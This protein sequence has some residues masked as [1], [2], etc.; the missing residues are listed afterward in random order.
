MPNDTIVAIAT[1][2][3]V[4]ALSIIRMSGPASI[5][6]AAGLARVEPPDLP[7]YGRMAARLHLPPPWPPVPAECWVMRAPHSFTREDVIELHLPGSLPLAEA[8][9]AACLDAGA[10]LAEPGEFTRRALR[11]G[12]IDL[13]RA[14][15]IAALVAAEDEAS[16]RAARARL[17]GEFSRRVRELRERCVH[18]CAEVEAGIDFADEGLEFISSDDLLGGI[19]SL[20][21]HIASLRS[22]EVSRG[23]RSGLPLVLILGAPNAGKSSLFNRLLGRLRT[24]VNAEAGT[25]RDVIIEEATIGGVRCRLADTPGSTSEDAVGL[26][27]SRDIRSPMAAEA[28]LLL[29]VHDPGGGP[30]GTP[31]GMRALPR[32]RSIVV[33]SKA[34][35][36]KGDT[37]PML[38][39]SPR[40]ARRSPKGEG[41]GGDGRAGPPLAGGLDSARAQAQA[42]DMPRPCTVS[43]LT[44]SG[45]AALAR[46]I[47][48]VLRRRAVRSG[49]GKAHGTVRQESALR[50]AHEALF[51]AERAI[52]ASLGAELVAAD[53]R[54]AATAL[55]S[56]TGE[57]VTESVLDE[58]FGNFCVGK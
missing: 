27:L 22:A 17:L 24:I 33:F 58:I 7:A 44:G 21:D 47:G 50:E 52:R 36:R 6:T 55:G 35:L 56:I 5:E 16:L 3:G 19:H 28:D 51:R 48:R 29:Y 8:V 12:R 41:G 34:D 54:A 4:S 39:S 43:S 13:V 31:A 18:L 30:S 2:A 53:L 25:T 26:D 49:A 1:P 57:G 42:G 40:P 32:G 45:C 14:E 38:H 37:R 9:L 46:A 15:A 11:Q 23:V 10:R 20:A